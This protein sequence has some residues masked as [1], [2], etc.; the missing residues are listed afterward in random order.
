MIMQGKKTAAPS[1]MEPRV[2]EDQHPRE[3][4][5]VISVQLA[6]HLHEVVPAELLQLLHA[7]LGPLEHLKLTLEDLRIALGQR[8]PIGV[9]R[10]LHDSG[11]KQLAQLRIQSRAVLELGEPER[12]CEERRRHSYG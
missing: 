12:D 3:R 1:Y 2:R 9:E 7:A 11:Q 5:G 6:D 10:T 4:R 8:P